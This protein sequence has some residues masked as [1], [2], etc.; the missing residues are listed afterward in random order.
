MKIKF[1]K[2]A[3]EISYK[4]PSKFKLSCLIVDKNKIVTWGINNMAKTHPSCKTWG[5]FQHAELN[6]L[7]GTSYEKT[8]GCTAYIY[9]ETLQGNIANSRPCPV[10]MIA[11]KQAGIKDIIYTSEKGVR[12]E[13][14]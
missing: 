9:R 10:C 8:R 5:N 13:R 4:S 7:I 12:K 11:L 1:L 14:I 2:I 6:A 3:K